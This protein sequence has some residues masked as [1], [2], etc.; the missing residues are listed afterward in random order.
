MDDSSK[1]S[2]SQILISFPLTFVNQLGQLNSMMLEVCLQ[3]SSI[4]SLHLV[5]NHRDAAFEWSVDAVECR[6]VGAEDIFCDLDGG[7]QRRRH[8]A[9]DR[10]RVGSRNATTVTNAINVRREDTE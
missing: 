10:R 1:E 2:I 6:V 3:V 9:F 4:D 5:V 7:C 8:D